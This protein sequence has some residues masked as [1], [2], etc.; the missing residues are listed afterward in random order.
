[1]D[2]GKQGHTPC[3]PFHGSEPK[4]IFRWDAG[5]LFHIH[6]LGYRKMPDEMYLS[7]LNE[8]NTQRDKYSNKEIQDINTIRK[9]DVF[10]FA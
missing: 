1:M 3:W 5:T 4:E 8:L 6:Q 9:W 10:T 7:W 2:A